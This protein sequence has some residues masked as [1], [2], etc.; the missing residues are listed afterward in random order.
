MDKGVAMVIMDQQDYYNKANT[1]PQDTNTYKVLNKN[2]TNSLK[3]KL[4]AILKDIKQTGSL[5][6]T[7]YK[8]IPPVQYPPNSTAFPKFIKVA[9]PSVP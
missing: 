1:L 6:N 5:S 8:H 7:K 2:P 4:K 3:N 9:P